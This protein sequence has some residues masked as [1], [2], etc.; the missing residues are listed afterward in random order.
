MRWIVAVVAVAVA[1][2]VP[3]SATPA[4]DVLTLYTTVGRQLARL[5]REQGRDV[6]TDLW[7]RFRWIRINDCLLDPKKR[8][9][10][11]QLLEKLRAD[12]STRDRG[13]AAN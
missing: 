1:G 3:A 10:A 12:I 9:Q 11:T 8:G 7:P 5:D 13:S 6:T 4:S 2:Q